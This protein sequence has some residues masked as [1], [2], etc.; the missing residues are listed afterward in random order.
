MKKAASSSANASKGAK[1][2]KTKSTKKPAAKKT[3]P[4]KQSEAAAQTTKAPAVPS[5]RERIAEAKRL[6]AMDRKASGAAV[7]E[8]K[9]RTKELA[10]AEVS[11]AHPL[12]N[13]DFP[14]TYIKEIS[15]KLDDPDHPV[16]LTWTGPQ[17][18]AQDSGPFRSSPGAGLKGLNCDDT[19]T[20]L[21][22]GSKC[23]PKGTFTV[24]GF[25][26]SL[27]SDSRATYVTWFV[28]ERGIGLHYFPS[29]PKSAASHGCVRL[30][31]KSVAQLIQSNSRIDLTSVFVDGTW[32]KPSKQW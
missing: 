2:S 21:R 22:S 17:A 24:S 23:T 25:Q 12:R 13:S 19:A 18:A 4:G 3:A 9:S 26:D 5:L 20:S 27:S 14:E 32:T 1:V 6:E 8:T 30:E 29:V 28:R 7:P 11:A 31:K 15:V 10:L 16:M